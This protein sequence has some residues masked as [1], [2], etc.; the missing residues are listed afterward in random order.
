M[1]KLRRDDDG[2]LPDETFYKNLISYAIVFKKAE[3]IARQHK[4]SAYRANAVT[5]T[6]ALLC[7]R[8][9]D[10]INVD[11]I[12]EN[13]EV[14]TSL[15]DILY[16]W[17]P[18]I[19]EEIIRSA[20]GLNVTEWCK[21]EECW[22]SMQTL[23]LNI[24]DDLQNELVEGQPLPT[25]GSIRGQTGESLTYEDR[26]NIAKAMQLSPEKWLKIHTWSKHPVQRGIALTLS[27]Y[28]AGGWRQVPS[29]KQ[30]KSAVKMIQRS[31]EERIFDSE[32][33]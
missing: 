1:E 8:T 2:W 33:D 17:M 11:K 6:I 31:E 20:E 30:A 14:S 29:K 26:E 18:D 12:W 10:R 24:A 22:R 28:A 5:Y 23:D 9:V 32:N 15:G 7:Y 19:H 27:G 25:V 16:G 3:S 21:K 13:Q 4:L